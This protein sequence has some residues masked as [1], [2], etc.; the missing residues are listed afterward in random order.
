MTTPPDYENMPIQRPTFG[1]YGCMIAGEE[2]KEG[3]WQKEEKGRIN[4][5]CDKHK[6]K[7]SE[8]IR[9]V[10]KDGYAG[11]IEKS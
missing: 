5:Y 7:G 11:I 3:K 2:G 6:P 1:C 9:D 10:V 4:Y 8:P